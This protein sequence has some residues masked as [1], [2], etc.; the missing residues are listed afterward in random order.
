MTPHEIEVTLL[1]HEIH[2]LKG[3]R[4][5]IAQEVISL[6]EVALKASQR[7]RTEVVQERLDVSIRLLQEFLNN[8]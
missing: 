3:Q 7:G 4:H 8:Q 1:R 6:L 5:R 2:E